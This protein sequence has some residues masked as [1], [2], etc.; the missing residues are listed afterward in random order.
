[1]GP[2]EWGPIR[3]IYLQYASDPMV[4]FSPDLLFE[5]PAWLQGE[6]GPDVSAYLRWF[7]V[8][9]CLQIAFDLPLATNVPLGYGHNYAPADYIDAWVSVTA[10]DGITDENISRLKSIFADRKPAT[11]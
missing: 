1:M 9:T 10:P 7:P 8:V 11:F 2:G 3:N 6:R 4:F 5:E